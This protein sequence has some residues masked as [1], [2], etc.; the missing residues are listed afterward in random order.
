M[1]PYQ[2]KEILTALYDELGSC[3]RVAARIGCNEKT[4]AIWAKKLGV[5]LKPKGMGA[6][7]HFFNESY[8]ENIDCEEKAYWLAFIFADGCIYKGDSPN[9]Y[10]LQINLKREDKHHLEAFQR[11]I[12]S[13]YKIQ[14]KIVNGSPASLLKINST[15]MCRDLMDKGVVPRKS[16]VAKPPV[17]LP[18]EFTNHFIRGLFDGDGS[19]K[20]TGNQEGQ[21]V[22]S[23]AGTKELMEWVKLQL[24]ASGVRLDASPH[25]YRRIWYLETGAEQSIEDIYNFL[26]SDA[27]IKLD[28]K[29]N[30]FL[31]HLS[32]VLPNE[33]VDTL[34]E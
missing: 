5:A 17:G 33:T 13:D 27:T 18:E 21:I 24:V 22:V 15:K 9:S 20:Y 28:R 6:K 25:P 1:K 29:Y 34:G 14:D 23:F 7:K 4:V 32:K 26:Y 16:L 30:R 10:R 11:C 2:D 12:G 31:T 8:F 3:K 19:A